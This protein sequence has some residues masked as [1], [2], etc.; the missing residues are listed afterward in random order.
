[1]VRAYIALG[2]NLGDRALAI[3]R[4]TAQLADEELSVTRSAPIYQT[5]PVGPPGQPEYYNTVVEVETT[6]TPDALLDHVKRLEKAL[7]RT[8]SVRWGPRVIDLDILLYGGDVL[9][10]PRLVV[11]HPEM[12]HRAFVLVPLLDLAPELMVPGLGLSV[13]SLLADLSVAPGEIVALPS[14]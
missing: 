11:P 13:R 10:G 6:K 9:R 5:A 4:A 3:A 12:H 7:G 1:M 14:A 2:S 8:E